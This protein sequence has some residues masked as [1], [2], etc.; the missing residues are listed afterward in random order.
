MNQPIEQQQQLQ[1]QHYQNTA[2][3]NNNFNNYQLLQ[4]H[5]QNAAI[6]R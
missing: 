3:Y 4:P 2:A 5:H 1:P 6:D